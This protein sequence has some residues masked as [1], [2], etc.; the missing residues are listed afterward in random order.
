MGLKGREL[1]PYRM[2]LHFLANNFW[3]KFVI[4]GQIWLELG[5]IWAKLGR[6]LG[7]IEAK[8]GKSD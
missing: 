7:K 5:E 6:I 3:V 4:F 8:F 2:Q 1:A